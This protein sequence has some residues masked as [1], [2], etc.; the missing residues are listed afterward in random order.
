MEALNDALSKHS[1]L[2][3][4][5]TYAML[6]AMPRIVLIAALLSA[7]WP[8]VA[9]CLAPAR[10]PETATSCHEGATPKPSKAPMPDCAT[11]ACCQA[12]L[13]QAAVAI[14]APESDVPALEAVATLILVPPA[15]PAE[16]VPAAAPDP[17]G[18]LL[19]VS[20]RGRAPPAIA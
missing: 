8:P 18:V 6:S 5:A 10:A 20:R 1:T 9:H 11:M 2:L 14:P 13:L 16:S 12:V 3:R 7:S 17:P 19:A 4:R 15:P